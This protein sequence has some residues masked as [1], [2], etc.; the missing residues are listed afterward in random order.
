V[1][2]LLPRTRQLGRWRWLPSFQGRPT[3][4]RES[5]H[6]A[7]HRSD[8]IPS[9]NGH[10]T[11]VIGRTQPMFSPSKAV[12]AGAVVFAI[13]GVMLIAQPFDQQANVPGAQTETIAPTWVT[14]DI[15]PAPSCSS[16]DSELDGDV[17]RNRNVE[18]SPQTWTYSDPRLT[19]EVSRRWNSDT[20][21][22]DEGSFSVGTDAAYLR[23]EGGGWVCSASYLEKG[24]GMF[25]EAVTEVG[26]LTTPA[27]GTAA[28]RASRPS[29]SLRKLRA[30]PRSSSHSSSPATSRR[31]PRH[32]LPSESA[33]TPPSSGSGVGG[34]SPCGAR[35]S[36]L[37][38]DGYANRCDKGSVKST[39]VETAERGRSPLGAHIRFLMDGPHGNM[40]HSTVP[41][42]MVGRACRFRTI[43][44]YWYVLSGEGEV[45]RRAPDG[46]EDVTRLVPG[47]CIDIPLGTAFQYRCT[48]AAPLV[49]TCTALPPWLGDDEALIIDGPWAPRVDPRPEARRSVEPQG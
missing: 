19:G 41:P 17:R 40:I 4:T 3:T 8:P 34:R 25:A 11:I 9:A 33:Q 24:S 35:G 2:A 48:G 32:R 36:S 31:C 28:T 1:Q 10:P 47:V 13:G 42:G 46:H 20:D 23:N 15:Q 7:D 37:I 39:T 27:P 45:W 49:F 21:Q 38:G 5:E 12:T 18:C 6:S 26:V 14:G 44:E 29:S 30:F 22:T 43:D 16:G